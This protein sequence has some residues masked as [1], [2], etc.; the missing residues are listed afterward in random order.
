MRLGFRRIVFKTLRGMAR[1]GGDDGAVPWSGV[2]LGALGSVLGFGVAMR[3]NLVT[4]FAEKDT[5]KALDA[6]W[7]AA[8]KVWYITDVADHTRF[9]RWIA[10]LE[11]ATKS[12][13]AALVKHERPPRLHQ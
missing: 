8:S 5:V 2:L 4:P 3:I 11:A 6:R 10:N 1:S 12:Q 9:K 13:L 7:D